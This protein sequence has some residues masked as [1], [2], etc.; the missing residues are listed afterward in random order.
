MSNHHRIEL[1]VF[2]SIQWIWLPVFTNIQDFVLSFQ[3]TKNIY[4][5][6]IVYNI[7]MDVD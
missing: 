2:L 4:L 1:E 6:P 3:V 7:S 5:F